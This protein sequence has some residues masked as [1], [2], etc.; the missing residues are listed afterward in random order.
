MN[1]HAVIVPVDESK[2]RGACTIYIGTIHRAYPN[3]KEAE[4][5]LNALRA[6]G[7]PIEKAAGSAA[8][9]VANGQLIGFGLVVAG[10]L[11][12]LA[13]IE[14]FLQWLGWL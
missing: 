13:W 14:P 5:E 9:D 11:S 3:R 1:R 10:G 12:C 2:P 8:D 7:L 4:A 6:G